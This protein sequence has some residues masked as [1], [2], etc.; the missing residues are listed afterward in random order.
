MTYN[1]YRRQ[2]L[3]SASS[4]ILWISQSWCGVRVSTSCHDDHHVSAEI[5]LPV[6]VS[7]S[8]LRPRLVDVSYRGFTPQSWCGV[9]VSMSCHDDHHV[10]AEIQLPSVRE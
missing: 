4:E 6:S 8:R 1:H 9:R 5:Q 3:F 10:S 7:G 2:Y